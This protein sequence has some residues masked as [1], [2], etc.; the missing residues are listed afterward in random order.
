M[1]GPTHP[2]ATGASTV[3]VGRLR[4]NDCRSVRPGAG[5]QGLRY[6]GYGDGGRA[7]VGGVGGVGRF[8]RF[9]TTKSNNVCLS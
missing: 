1:A 9:P 2:L 6:R 7:S 8:V 5:K 4:K 3:R